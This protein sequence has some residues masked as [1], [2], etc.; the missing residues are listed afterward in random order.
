MAIVGEGGLV[1]RIG[2]RFFLIYFSLYVLLTQ[3]SMALIPFDT[4]DFSGI[5]ETKPVRAAVS[6]AGRHFS[7]VSNQMVVTGSGSGDKTFDW[8]LDFC[9]LVL[10][11]LAAATWSLLDRQRRNYDALH[12]WFRLFVR[13]SLAATMITYGMAKVIPLQ[14]PAP[15]LT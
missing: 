6:W 14:M 2:F 8:V 4:G 7:H 5:Q 1:T 15:T 3:M 12:S 11:C 10:A 9:I 13:F